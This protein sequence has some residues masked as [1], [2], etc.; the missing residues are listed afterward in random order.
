MVQTTSTVI[1]GIGVRD[2]SDGYTKRPKFRKEM[3]EV[4]ERERVE[5]LYWEGRFRYFSR[6]A[7]CY[8][9]L[10][11]LQVHL[12]IYLDILRFWLGD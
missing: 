3:S 1:M 10:C 6:C 9:Y 7:L 2:E 4:V 5:F 8:L 12:L 11:L